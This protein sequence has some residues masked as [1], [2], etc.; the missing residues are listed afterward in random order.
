MPWQDTC[1]E[2]KIIIDNGFINMVILI[3][4]FVE[5]ISPRFPV[6]EMPIKK[7]YN[8]NEIGTGCQVDFAV[9]FGVFTPTVFQWLI[10]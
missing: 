2:M 5:I 8:N 3:Y 9:I 10:F 7:V 1:H 6:Y 4:S